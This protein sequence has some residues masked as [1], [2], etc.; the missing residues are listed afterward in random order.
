VTK[1][2]P[3]AAPPPA[4]PPPVTTSAP[5]PPPPPAA[6]P[7]P[8]PTALVAG[9]KTKDWIIAVMEVEDLNAKSRRRRV[10]KGLVR[11]L[12]DQLRIFIAQAGVRT[13][14]KSSQDRA[15]FE[16]LSQLKKDS[17]KA[18]YDDSCQIE[19]GKAL[20]ASHILRS[21]ITKFGKKCVLNGELIDLKAEVTVKAASAQG[22][23]EAEG[24]LTMCERV[25][26]DLV[27]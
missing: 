15:L 3:P 8:A 6:P 2:P 7:P 5:P 18:C 20:A 11:N 17:Y 26:Q 19:L 1:A 14:D 25:A 22:A 27:R 10:D 23:C 16:Q 12:G 24:F 9:A 4:P 21:R 13:I